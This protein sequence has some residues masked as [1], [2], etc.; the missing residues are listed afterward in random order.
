MSDLNHAVRAGK[1]TLDLSQSLVHVPWKPIV[2]SIR[3]EPVYVKCERMY[4]YTALATFDVFVPEG[5]S[6]FFCQVSPS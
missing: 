4:K 5:L 6:E 2:T 3:G 1:D